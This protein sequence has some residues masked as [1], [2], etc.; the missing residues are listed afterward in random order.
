MTSKEKFHDSDNG[1]RQYYVMVNNNWIPVSETESL[2]VDKDLQGY[3]LMTFKY[4]GKQ[5]RS[6]VALR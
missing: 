5:Y 4:K 2:N 6:R 3:I 1:N